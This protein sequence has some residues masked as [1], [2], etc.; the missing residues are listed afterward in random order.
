MTAAVSITVITA[1]VLLKAAVY[2]L[3]CEADFLCCT[4]VCLAHNVHDFKKRCVG[5]QDRFILMWPLG[6]TVQ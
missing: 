5:Q 1:F 6:Y 2:A 3:C 4:N